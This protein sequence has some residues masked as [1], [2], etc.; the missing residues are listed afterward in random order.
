MTTFTSCP[1]A[2]PAGVNVLEV[3]RACTNVLATKNSYS[4]PPDAVKTIGSPLQIEL[5]VE[6]FVNVGFAGRLFIVTV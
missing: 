6:S 5:F 3:L 1:F 4:V 2:I